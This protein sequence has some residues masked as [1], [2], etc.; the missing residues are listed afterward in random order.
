MI[1]LDRRRFVAGLAGAALL[2]SCALPTR[3]YAGP[4]LVAARISADRVTRVMVGLRPYRASGFVVR[5]EPF[6]DK[7]LVHNYGHGGGGI[8]LCWGSSELAVEAGFR[9]AGEAHA[10][11][12]CGVMGLTT[13]TLLQARGVP[14]TIYAKSLPPHTTSNIAGGHWSPYSVFREGE[15]SPGFLEQFH[16]AAR[17]AYRRF[18]SLEGPR[19]GIS[20]RRNYVINDRFQPWAPFRESLRDVMPASE[21]LG[22]GDHPF[23]DTYVQTWRSM[24]IEPPVFLAALMDDFVRNGGRIET[25]ELPDREAIAALP[26]AT[27][28]NC[29]GLG[30]RALFGDEGMQPARGQLVMLDPQPGVDYNTFLGGSYMFPRS[31]GIVLGGTFDRGNW[32]LEPDD[33]ATARIIAGNARAMALLEG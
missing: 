10:V 14:V 2:S 28:F 23:G 7:L 9:R 32:S 31:D 1:H 33:G 27:I 18:E 20:W 19:Y 8:T 25:R 24:M 15:A 5:A 29:T 21:L 11:I 13:A 3:R 12:G 26:E 6:G 4:R 16:R 30:A 17:I 22:P